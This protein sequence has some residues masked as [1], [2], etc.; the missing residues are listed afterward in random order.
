MKHT[1]SPPRPA[2]VLLTLAVD[3]VLVLAFAISGR[4]SHDETLG[5]AGVFETAWPFLVA[6]AAGWLICRLWQQPLRIF[7]HGI[8]LWLITVVGGMALRI[9]SGSTAALPFVVVAT[10][11]LA[12]FLLGQRTVTTLVLR[13][14]A[15]A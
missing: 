4:R 11:V 14:T 9:L 6:L 8:C 12:L 13:R 2:L 7:P 10:L 3:I 15:K 5:A 1:E